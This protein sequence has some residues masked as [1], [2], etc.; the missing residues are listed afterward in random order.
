MPS[1]Q[2][3]TVEQTS[4]ALR[5][6]V[7]P[8]EARYFFDRLTNPLWIDALN[9]ADFLIP[10]SPILDES[11]TRYPRWPVSSFIARVAGDHP[12][13]ESL[14]RIL[15]ELLDTENISIQQD[16]LRAMAALD[17]GVLT[18][19]LPSVVD[20]F[21][22]PWRISWLID[23]LG[24]LILNALKDPQNRGGVQAILE[25][26][27]RPRWREESELLGKRASSALSEWEAEQFALRVLPRLSTDDLLLT[28][29]V[30][31]GTL[32]ALL[33]EMRPEAPDVAGLRD[34]HSVIWYQR[35]GTSDLLHDAEDILVFLGVGVLDALCKSQ[36]PVG[37]VLARL[38]VSHWVI[39]ERMALRFL[40]SS[41]DSRGYSDEVHQRLTRADRASAYQTRREFDLLLSTAFPLATPAQQSE[42][43]QTLQ[44]AASA[45]T[46]E[47][48]RWLYGRLIH[49]ADH[50]QD[51]WRESFERFVQQFGEAA[52]DE[53]FTFVEWSGVVS[54]LS[55]D[56]AKSMS[57]GELAAF[58]R[59]WHGSD[60]V[61]R[62]GIPS[63]AGLA[64]DIR[65]EAS[66]RP[67]EFSDAIAA[68]SDLN[69]TILR[70]VLEV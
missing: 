31:V 45:K 59:S 68:F 24:D 37:E 51:E 5:L 17:P 66:G 57:A 69:P 14:A 61:R 36:N 49:I 44:E 4:E 12:D 1:W 53:P 55:D 30:V 56:S 64:A 62:I 41:L 16:M 42:V 46:E 35:L 39:V 50:L 25:A 63:W 60:E 11:G 33:T 8:E 22:M 15:R 9:D 18:D 10:P 20:W 47:Q 6:L 13:Q 65:E 34:D 21:S 48:E 7:R 67:D 58:A 3:P 2:K 27:L 28:L 54:P 19:L 70:A 43:L 32:D 29:E 23:E 52:S 26:L 40:A 38:T